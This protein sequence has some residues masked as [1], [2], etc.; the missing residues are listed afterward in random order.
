MTKNKRHNLNRLAYFVEVYEQRT[1]TG[2]AGRLDV[3]K[4]VVSKQIQLLEDDV[5]VALFRR[6][7]RKI[8]PTD[9][10]VEFYQRA[11]ASVVQA[12][13]AF[14][15]VR[16]RG[17]QARGALRVTATVEYGSTR[18]VPLIS[19]FREQ[20]PAVSVELILA[21]EQLDLIA[22]RL[23]LAFRVG[24]LADSLNRARKL[25][26]FTEIPV[27]SPDLVRNAAVDDPGQLLELPFI[28][29]SV[30]A[31]PAKWTFRKGRK[32]RSLR[33]DPPITVNNTGATRQLVLQAAG[34]A[35][36]PNFAVENDLADGRLIRLV[37]TWSLRE[38][39][40]YA[41]TPPGRAHG[42]ALRELLELA[43]VSL[44]RGSGLD[45]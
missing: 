45:G 38:G 17:R 22:E 2:A 27:C 26:E 1:I 42:R 12:N 7:T 21:N 28:A 37:P 20:F 6:N 16:D 32:R 25:A 29:N 40:V 41:V 15:M 23:D 44:G 43:Q 31:S 30:V 35:I 5:G 18:V 9:A 34:F 33:F 36:V 11:K 13:D 14:E 39:A 10:G 19:A 3:S 4:A 24:W 8:A